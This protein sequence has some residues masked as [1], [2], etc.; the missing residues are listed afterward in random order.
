[1]RNRFID[2]HNFIN[3]VNLNSYVIDM[4]WNEIKIL[5]D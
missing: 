4:N 1:M 5:V 2:K 3:A